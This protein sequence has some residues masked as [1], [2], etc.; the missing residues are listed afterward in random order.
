MFCTTGVVLRRLQGDSNL[1]AMSHLII[2]EVHERTVQS[3]FL[4]VV[5]KRILAYQRSSAHSARKTPLKVR[6]RRLTFC[7]STS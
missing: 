3:D 5:V 2:D 6:I 7:I 4:L 1:D